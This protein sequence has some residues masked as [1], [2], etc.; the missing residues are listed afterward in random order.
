MSEQAQADIQ[1]YGY[2]P[3]DMPDCFLLITLT[4]FFSVSRSIAQDYTAL[5]V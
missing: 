5:V 2:N 1:K 3:K 4:K